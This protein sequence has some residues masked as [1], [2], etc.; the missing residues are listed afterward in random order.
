MGLYLEVD[1]SESI[2]FPYGVIIG[3]FRAEDL[4]AEA[5][6]GYMGHTSWLPMK[7]TVVGETQR[8]TQ[9]V[10]RRADVGGPVTRARLH[11]P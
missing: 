9:H 4:V 10:G 3:S 1:F 11:S 7:K 5:P 2:P 8:F 6:A